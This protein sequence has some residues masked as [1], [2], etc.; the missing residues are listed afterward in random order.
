MHN[1]SLG[2]LG[3]RLRSISSFLSRPLVSTL[4]AFHPNDLGH[5]LFL[6]PPEWQEW[7][8]WPVDLSNGHQPQRP[9]QEDPWL[10]LLRYYESCLSGHEPSNQTSLIPPILRSLISDA[11]ELALPR[12]IGQLYPNRRPTSKSPH[13]PRQS[14]SNH[15]PGMSPKKAHEVAHLVAHLATLMSPGSPLCDIRHVVDIGAGQG[16]LSRELRD[17]LHLHVLA[18]DWSDVQTQG[19]ARREGS[20]MNRKATQRRRPETDDSARKPAAPSTEQSFPPVTNGS[21]TY[22]TT[23]IDPDSL[24][25]STKGWLEDIS[26]STIAAH[27]P[28]QVTPV[29]FVALH[30]CGSLTSDILRAF[31]SVQRSNS[32]AP[33]TPIT[34]MPQGAVVVGCC[35]N[36]MR[37]EDLPLSRTLCSCSQYPSV[38]LSPSHLQLAAQVPS[39]WTRSEQTLEQ[40]RFALRK[41]VWRALLQDAF[42]MRQD[43]GGQGTSAE[44]SNTIGPSTRADRIG[45][46]NDAAYANWGTFCNAIRVKL[47]LQHHNLPT[48]PP[49]C[50][51]RRVEVFH[52]LRCILGPVVE[53]LILLD[54]LTW[55]FEE[56]DG[57]LF[58]VHLVNLF[59]QASGSGRNVAIAIL[60][61]HETLS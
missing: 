38:H 46:L 52:V 13:H 16:Y 43:E 58:T 12:D 35:Y 55:M 29:L 48:T 47:H 4:F 44:R 18:L 37:S 59:D 32:S 45:R 40:A 1:T 23:S 33:S 21:L 36:M 50:S 60:P 42:K 54:R 22:I 30:A 39:Q 56:L 5:S 53:S 20:K 25:T 2:S 19:A 41:I 14:E 8:D 34:W 9:D 31:A 10:L 61:N 6:P 11:C 24:V 28:V 57:S 51:E 17:Q 49:L 27:A 3:D 7:W 15:L 26:P